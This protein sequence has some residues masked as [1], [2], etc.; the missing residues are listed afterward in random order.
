MLNIPTTCPSCNTKVL[1]IKDQIFCTKTD[2]EGKQHKRVTAFA[3]K[4]KIIGL[5]PSALCKLNIEEVPS[6]YKL[7]KNECIEALGKAVGTKVFSSIQKARSCSLQDFI[8]SLSIPHV[9]VTTAKG[10]TG[11]NLGD[12]EYD[13][14]PPSAQESLDNWVMEEL[15]KYTDLQLIFSKEANM[16]GYSASV[17]IT[18]KLHGMTKADAELLLNKNGIGLAKNVSKDIDALICDEPKNSSKERKAKELGIKIS[19]FKEYM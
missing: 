16:E 9:G 10:I 7:S 3:K 4:M 14:L 17:C 8:G 13:K 6:I 5:G 2:C 18:G 1:R 12:F 11:S 19:T 15:S